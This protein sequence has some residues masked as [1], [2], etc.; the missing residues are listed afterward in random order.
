MAAEA[1]TNA[2]DLRGDLA[3]SHPSIFQWLRSHVIR[4]LS[5]GIADQMV[6]S[7]TNFAVAIYIVRTLGA[8]S[9]ACSAWPT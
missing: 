3:G 7:L 9:S 6:S 2:S 8:A 5:W 1:G 4:R